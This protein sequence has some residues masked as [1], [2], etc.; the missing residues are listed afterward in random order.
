MFINMMPP[1][2]HRVLNFHYEMKKAEICSSVS[3]LI[4]RKLTFIRI[5]RA[6]IGCYT[7]N[8]V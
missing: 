5:G 7:Q 3:C 4:I 6:D 2:T 8:M 1:A